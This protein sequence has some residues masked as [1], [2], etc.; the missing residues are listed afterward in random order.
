MTK[1]AQTALGIMVMLVL[2]VGCGPRA[3]GAKCGGGAACGADTLCLGEA[4]G[5]SEGLCTPV[6]RCT[7][8]DVGWTCPVDGGSCV[9]ANVVY[10]RCLVNCP[11]VPVTM[12]CQ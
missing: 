8:D 12:I 9:G 10:P 11:R 4:P 3:S 5:Q 1:R 6:V 2:A 7:I